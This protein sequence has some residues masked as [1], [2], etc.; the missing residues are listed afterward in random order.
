FEDSINELIYAVDK[1]SNNWKKANPLQKVNM[2]LE[3]D[4][5]DRNNVNK[6]VNLRNELIGLEKPIN[7][8]EDK[9][10]KEIPNLPIKAD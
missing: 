5:E 3:K 9:N 7:K 2:V 4:N 6:D 1:E 8:L 10:I